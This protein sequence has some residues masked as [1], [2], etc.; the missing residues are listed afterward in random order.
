MKYRLGENEGR[1]F[2]R[3]LV[4]TIDSPNAYLGVAKQNVP[5][6]A[7]VNTD[8]FGRT[9]GS[10]DLRSKYCLDIQFRML[11]LND[12][13]ASLNITVTD[14]YHAACAVSY[15]VRVQMLKPR[16]VRIHNSVYF[17]TPC[18]T[19]TAVSKP[20]GSWYV[21]PKP[22]AWPSPVRGEFASLSPLQQGKGY[23]D[24]LAR[25]LSILSA[26]ALQ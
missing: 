10:K 16:G 2:P 19:T 12:K 4:T 13:A 25:L 3:F 8:D 23:A 11:D 24:P 22:V 1:F 5:A 21:N 6:L 18:V 7:T 26:L 9:R 14:N 20:I 15:R 17:Y